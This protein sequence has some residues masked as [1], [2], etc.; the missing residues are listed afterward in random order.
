MVSRVKG[1]LLESF[2]H[3]FAIC[4]P[5]L[6]GVSIDHVSDYVDGMDVHE[7][8]GVFN[9]AFCLLAQK[10]NWNTQK[11]FEV[12][13]QANGHGYWWSQSNFFDAACGAVMA[14]GNMGYETVDVCNAFLQVGADPVSAGCPPIA[15]C[16][17]DNFPPH[18]DDFDQAT[19]IASLPLS[20]SLS[21]SMATDASDDPSASC[22]P[23]GKTVWY[24][25]TTPA[26]MTIEVN[27]FGSDFDTVLAAYVGTRG[28]LTQIGC[29]DDTSSAQSQLFLEV[30]AG[31]T[32]F[33]MVGGYNGSSGNLIFTVVPS[34]GPGGPCDSPVPA[35]YL[36]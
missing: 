7:S 35:S 14:A 6:D 5:T 2:C 17:T 24:S 32:V 1:F 33:F 27:T 8:S 9:K 22:A 19:Q 23:R 36:F 31:Q 21:T 3:A 15:G 12:M 28:Q 18:N 26:N 11:A 34:T 13:L 20:D 30:S 29:N 16:S 25:L 4:E 10:P